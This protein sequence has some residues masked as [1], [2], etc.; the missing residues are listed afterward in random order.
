MVVLTFVN[1]TPNES[2]E[3]GDLVC[4]EDDED[5]IFDDDELKKNIKEFLLIMSGLI[6]LFLV[7]YLLQ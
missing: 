4:L 2:L 7:L 6:S 1:G 5:F 3:I